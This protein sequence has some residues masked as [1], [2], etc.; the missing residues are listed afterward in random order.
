MHY[1]AYCTWLDDAE[2]KRFMPAAKPVT[3][4]YAANHQL[5]FHAAGERTDRGWCHLN[6]RRRLG[7]EG[8]GRGLRAP[9]STSTEDYD[10]FERCCRHGLWR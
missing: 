9:E 7:K 1:F 3:K 6:A 10:D 5:R 8:L 4:G 2:L